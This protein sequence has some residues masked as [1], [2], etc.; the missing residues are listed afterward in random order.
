MSVGL[1]LCYGDAGHV[2]MIE[3]ESLA[4]QVALVNAVASRAARPIDWVSFT[5]PQ[6]RG[7]DAYFAPLGDLRIGAATEPYLGVVPYHPDRQAEGVRR[8]QI[9]SID[10]H[11][12][13]DF[14]SWGISTECGLA[15]ADRADI[16]RLLDL[17]RELLAGAG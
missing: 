2:H 3:P 7:D 11:L 6:D 1:H 5:V 4:A 10:R 15:R 16:A 17:H 8:R 9:A 14:A 13:A 12:P